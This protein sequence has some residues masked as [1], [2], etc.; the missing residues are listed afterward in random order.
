MNKYFFFK[1][2]ITKH[3]LRVMNVVTLEDLPKTVEGESS[4]FYFS[5]PKAVS[6]VIKGDE[7][8]EKSSSSYD[9]E[10]RKGQEEEEEELTWEKENQKGVYFPTPTCF[11]TTKENMN[12][13][14]RF[15][16]KKQKIFVITMYPVDFGYDIEKDE[17]LDFLV[18]D[19]GGPT[20]CI[21]SYKKKG[22]ISQKEF[23][24]FIQATKQ[25]SRCLVQSLSNHTRVPTLSNGQHLSMWDTFFHTPHQRV[26]C[27][28]TSDNTKKSFSRCS[29]QFCRKRCPIIDGERLYLCITSTAGEH[30]ERELDEYVESCEFNIDQYLKYE[31]VAKQVALNNANRLAALYAKICQFKISVGYEEDILNVLKCQHSNFTPHVV[32][33]PTFIQYCNTTQVLNDQWVVSYHGTFDIYQNQNQKQKQDRVVVFVDELKSFITVPLV[34]QPPQQQT[35]IIFPIQFD[36]LSELDKYKE[37][38]NTNYASKQDIKDYKLTLALLAQKKLSPQSIYLSDIKYKTKTEKQNERKADALVFGDYFSPQ[39]RQNSNN[40][41]GKVGEDEE[42]NLNKPKCLKTY[43]I[44][45]LLTQ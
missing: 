45:Q 19:V 36:S 34:I 20:E 38:L 32:G 42:S 14:Y 33:I 39:Q 37:C 26:L 5:T 22:W 11:G 12:Q 16:L 4:F 15:F 9:G 44:H 30:I 7:M 25:K 17:K 3:N 35:P 29:V 13:H 24:Q 2:I 31:N 1:S 21:S 40:V 43:K 23:S 10:K 6:V 18:S 28:S 41:E 27:G 8:V